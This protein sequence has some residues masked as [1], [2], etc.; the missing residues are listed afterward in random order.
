MT[1]GFSEAAERNKG[2]IA[3]VLARELPARGHV[4]EIA[5]GS[6]QHVV[7]FARAL[8][9]LT[10]Q[11]S[12]PSE[13]ARNS[14]AAYLAEEGLANVAQPIA[15][16]VLAGEPTHAA[17]A[18]VCLN[19]IHIAPWEATAGLFAFADRSLSARGV[20][21]TYGPYRFS[22]AFTAPSNEAFDRSLKSRNAA[23]GVRDVDDV[24]REAARLGLLRVATHALP[25]NNHALVFRRAR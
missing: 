14:I 9:G 10:F 6:G 21:V 5:S 15:I 19:M 12:D 13:E 7:H 4:V 17:D 20:L 18:V 11:P 1:R 2:P 23:W 16:D 24:D 3:E 8:P 22:G 25:A